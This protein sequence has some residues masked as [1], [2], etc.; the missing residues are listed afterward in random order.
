M[1]KLTSIFLTV[2]ILIMS[3]FSVSASA[4]EQT[5]T[6]KWIE[7]DSKNEIKIQA[8][9][10]GTIQDN[11]ET[12]MTIMHKNGKILICFSI[13]VSDSFSPTVK[14]IYEDNNFFLYFP[15]FPYLHIKLPVEIVGTTIYDIGFIS[16]IDFNSVKTYEEKEGDKIYYV[17]EFVNENGENEKYFFIE[18]DLVKIE[19]SFFDENGEKFLTTL[20][21]TPSIINDKVFEIPWYSI[22]VFPLFFLFTILTTI[23]I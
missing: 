22:N 18:D 6:E 19:T 16:E 9:S 17:E 20:L 2:I 11:L 4:Q 14:M 3:V 13:P 23:S 12:E 10:V 21:I 15:S 5:R 7:S 8:K 1:K